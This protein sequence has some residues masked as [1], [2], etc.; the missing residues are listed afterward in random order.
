MAMND[1]PTAETSQR[2]EE[3]RLQLVEAVS[4]LIGP[5]DLLLQEQQALVKKL[6]EIARR[7]RIVSY[8]LLL[9]CACS[10]VALAAFG[11]YIGLTTTF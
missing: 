4:Q 5:M 8:L 3:R 11:F 2:I 10:L 6:D 9:M 1:K 7:L